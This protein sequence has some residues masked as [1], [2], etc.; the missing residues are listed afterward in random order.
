MDAEQELYELMQNYR[1][2]PRTLQSSVIDCFEAVKKYIQ[3]REQAAQ[4]EAFEA[5]RQLYN[6]YPGS[7]YAFATFADYEARRSQTED[8]S[9][10]SLGKSK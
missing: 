10:A 3:Q 1:M 6:G 8:R 4:R 7:G 9:E 2:A 5:G